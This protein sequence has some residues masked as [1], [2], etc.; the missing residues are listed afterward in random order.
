[1]C[2]VSYDQASQVQE[3][4]LTIHI[5][6]SIGT[7]I[8]AT[9]K[10]VLHWGWIA[11]VTHKVFTAPT[12]PAVRPAPLPPAP[13]GSGQLSRAQFLKV[14]GLGCAASLLALTQAVNDLQPTETAA[15][16]TELA[17]QTSQA[18]SSSLT[19]A[20]QACSVRCDRRCSYPGHCH[21]YVDTNN[22]GRCDHGEC[23]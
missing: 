20:S 17:S 16:N 1:M 3:P 23:A 12:A 21:D 10:I 9:L 18:S 22:N 5:L 14:A 4:W 6:A 13:P 19:S 8:L 11:A 2:R 15:A 7:L